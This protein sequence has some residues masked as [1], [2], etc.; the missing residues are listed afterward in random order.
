MR[1]IKTLV[2]MGALSVSSAFGQT[3]VWHHQQTHDPFRPFETRAIDAYSDGTAHYVGAI[4]DLP[5]IPAPSLRPLMVHVT[6]NLYPIR[7]TTYIRPGEDQVPQNT[8]LKLNPQEM[9]PTIDGGTIVCGDFSESTAAGGVVLDGAFLLKLDP[10]HNVMWHTI[11]PDID[12]FFDVFELAIPGGPIQYMV[13]GHRIPNAATPQTAVVALTNS[14]GGLIWSRDV[15]SLK[16]GFRGGSVYNQL[17]D[18][19]NG[20]AALVGTA[21]IRNTPPP[22]S[23]PLDADVLVTGVDMAGNVFFNRVYGSTSIVQGGNTY[24][25]IEKGISLDFDPGTSNIFVTGDIAAKSLTTTLPDLFEDVLAFRMDG[26]GNILWAR[27]YDV[28]DRADG[29]RDIKLLGTGATGQISSI[30]ADTVTS[31]FSPNFSPDL[32]YFQLDP[33]GNPMGLADVFGGSGT[34]RVIQHLAPGL[35]P[36]KR[37]MD[38][39]GTTNSFGPTYPV[40]YLIERFNAVCRRCNDLQRLLRVN[41]VQLPTLTPESTFFQTFLTSRQLI[42][43]P[44]DWRDTD[45]CPKC[46]IGDMNCDGIVSV[47]DIGPFVLAVTNPAGYVAT[48]PDCC[49]ESADINCDGFIT[50]ADIGPFVALLTGP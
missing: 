7:M 15:W 49:L 3:Y 41:A 48:F 29:G 26:G 9:F 24:S 5:I 46:L 33:A 30:V 40:G 6:P 38:I 13:C 39:L 32:A 20:R 37:A 43:R 25:M 47:A 44:W 12:S 36:Q 14:L 28:Q 10:G 17:I 27:R 16:N 42:A 23:L 50:V 8:F 4:T 45:E 11:Y 18:T 34:D 35:S 21:N 2:C 1:S 22:L 31:F 19:G